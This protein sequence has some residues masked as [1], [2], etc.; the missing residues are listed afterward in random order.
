MKKLEI[1]K[2]FPTLSTAYN[3]ESFVIDA[4]T[5]WEELGRPQG[6]FNKWIKRKLVDKNYKEN[7]DYIKVEKNIKM[8]SGSKYLKEYTLTLDCAKSIILLHT[9]C[10]NSAYVYKYLCTL[11]NNNNKEIIIR[12]SQRKEISFLDKLEKSLEPFG[13]IGVRQ[14]SLFNGKYRIDYYIESMEVAIEYDE[15]GHRSY[16][17]EAEEGRQKEIEES[18]KCRFIRVS[19][20]YSDEYNIGVVIKNIFKL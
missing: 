11:D 8:E 5:I 4:R 6:E 1:H 7:I 15:I 9:K 16:T 2:R 13:I 10:P 17:Y 3:K 18:L 12:E 20:K 14:Y 19:E